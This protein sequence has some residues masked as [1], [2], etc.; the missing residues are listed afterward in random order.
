M[1]RRWWPLQNA[2]GR[3]RPASRSARKSL[4]KPDWSPSQD[5]GISVLGRC[6]WRFRLYIMNEAHKQYSLLD[7]ILN[8]IF[9]LHLQENIYTQVPKKHYM[10]A[11]EAGWH[12]AGAFDISMDVFL[13]VQ[14]QKYSSMLYDIDYGLHFR[15]KYK[16][17]RRSAENL[18]P[19]ILAK[20]PVWE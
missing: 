11:G 15:T 10:S 7:T 17:S 14:D 5:A 8:Y 2:R 9:I 1:G 12:V 16:C 4:E 13:E 19:N 3:V 6:P 20:G 18:F